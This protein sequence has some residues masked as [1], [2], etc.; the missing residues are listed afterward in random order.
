M[1]NFDAELHIIRSVAR[2][3]NGYDQK[4]GSYLET[5]RFRLYQALEADD[6]C[7]V[8]RW[9]RACRSS[10]DAEVRSEITR[11]RALEALALIESEVSA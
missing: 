9:L 2:E 7:A 3:V 4:A 10:V 5:A 8:S 1:R 11:G 6:M